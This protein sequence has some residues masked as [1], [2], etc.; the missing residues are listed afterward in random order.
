MRWLVI[1]MVAG[2]AL[3]TSGF[4][5]ELENTTVAS[6]AL[7]HAAREAPET[8]LEG[9]RE[10]RDLPVLADLTEQQA[11]AFKILADALDVSAQRVFSLT[12]LIE[13][14]AGR[15]DGL[16]TTLRGLAR[17][18]TCVG[19]RLRTLTGITDNVSPR[20]RRITT[21]LRS[22]IDSQ[23]KSERHL[24]SINRK[25]TLLGVAAEVSDVKVPPPP[26]GGS[27]VEVEIGTSPRRGCPGS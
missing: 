7:A 24:R 25:L 27:R 18:S 3:A 14:Q 8:A 1:P 10:V 17:T 6:T 23:E 20:L 26:R 15:I 21:T 22:L 12:D 11:S 5:H 13:A 9:T 16:R 4:L 2:L 19:T